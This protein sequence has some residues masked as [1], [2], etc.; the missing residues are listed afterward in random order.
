MALHWR[1][2][3]GAPVRMRRGRVDGGGCYFY[4][5][6]IHCWGGWGLLKGYET[7][8]RCGWS[9][10]SHQVITEAALFCSVCVAMVPIHNICTNPGRASCQGHL[11]CGNVWWQCLWVTNVESTDTEN[12]WPDPAETSLSIFIFTSV[13]TWESQSLSRQIWTTSPILCS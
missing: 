2:L 12:A 5:L 10:A 3:T 9:S 1:L 7:G 13:L 11:T 6:W 4:R 8:R